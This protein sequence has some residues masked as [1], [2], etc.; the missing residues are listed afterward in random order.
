MLSLNSMD[1]QGITFLLTQLGDGDRR[2]D[3]HGDR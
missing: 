3:H 1:N 2:E